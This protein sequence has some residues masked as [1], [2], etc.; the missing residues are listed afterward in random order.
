MTVSISRLVA[1]CRGGMGR[2]A[3]FARTRDASD[4]QSSQTAN[5]M[6]DVAG[7]PQRPRNTKR[8]P[9]CGSRFS[10]CCTCRAR[11]FMPRRMSAWPVAIHPSA[12]AYR[13]C[14]ARTPEGMGIIA[15]AVLSSPPPPGQDQP[16]RK[17]EAGRR[18][19]TQARSAEYPLASWAVSQ[20]RSH[21]TAR[22][23]QG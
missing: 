17:Y 3:A 10:A 13:D 21:Q 22:S 15:A 5:R 18:A 1:A 6:Q 11:P 2:P 4:R 9:A 23:Q 12:I 16:P 14:S 19:Q 8:S 7:W 20:V